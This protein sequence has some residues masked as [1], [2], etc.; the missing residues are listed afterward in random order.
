MRLILIF[1]AFFFSLTQIAL[2]EGP[3]PEKRVILHRDTDFPGGDIQSIFDTTLEACES[4]CLTREDCR[5]FT[6]NSR[7]QACFLKD[8]FGTSESYSGAFSGEIVAAPPAVVAGAEARAERLDFLYESDIAQAQARAR[9]LPREFLSGGWSAEQLLGWAQEAEA[10]AN[11]VSAMRYTA[12]AT[13]ISDAGQDWADYA[14]LANS[15]AFS[16]TNQSERTKLYQTAL[17]AAISGYLRAASPAQEANALTEMATALENLG[18]GRQ[19][20]SALRLAQA[21]SPRAETAEA[22]DRAVGLYGFRV[23]DSSVESDAASPRI[24]AQF[25][26]SLVETGVDYAPFVQSDVSGL[27]VSARG[28]QLCVEGVS[29]GNRYALTLRAGLPA[30]SGEELAKPVQLNL[31][32]RD[33]APSVR[34]PGRAY[35][36][37]ASPDA[38]LPIVAVN[39]SE[40]ELTLSRLPDRNLVR[41]Y[42]EDWFGRALSTWDVSWFNETLAEPIWEGTAQVASELNRDVTTRLP[43]GEALA[44]QPPG[45]YVLHAVVPGETQDSSPPATQWF[46]IS[47]IGLTTMMGADG[48]HVFARSLGSAEPIAGATVQLASRANAVLGE[49]VTDAAGYARFPEGMTSGRAGAEPAMLTLTK[50]DDI[51]FL[52]LTGPAFDLSDRGVEGHAAAPPID[53]FLTT[54][55]G[56]YR[57]GETVHATA[58]ARDDRAEAIEGLPLIAVLSR[59]DGVEYSRHLSKGAGAGGHVFSLPLAGNAPRG[60]WRLDLFADPDA[61]ALSSTTLLVEDFLPERI[62]FD[63]ALSSERPRLTERPR[64]K[65]EARYLFG[66]PAADLAIEGDLR[67]RSTREIAEWPGYRFGPHEDLYG[68]Q[69]GMIPEART[70]ASG[71]AEFAVGFPDAETRGTPLVAEINIRVKE[72]SGRP[73][74]RSLNVPVAP[75]EPLIGIRPG[76]D[77]TVPEGA[78]ASFDLIALAPDLGL[79]AMEVSWELNRVETRYQ[80]YSM[81]GNW[82]WEPTTTRTR[83]ASGE[84]MLGD[85]PVRVS[86]PTDWGRYELVVSE[87][88]GSYVASSVEFFAGWYAPADATTTPDMLEVSLDAPAYAPGDTATLRFVPRAAGKA[89]VTVV[90]NRLIDMVAVDAVAGENTVR[91]PVTE[92]WGAGAYVMATMIRPLDETEGREPTRALGLTH[93]SVDPGA[94]QLAAAFDVPAE[95][96][97]RGPLEVVL[98]VD[99]VADG[100]SAWATIAAVDV[101]ILNLTSFEAP[102]PSDHYFGQRRLG[103]AVRDLYGRLIDG[104]SGAM[105]AIRSG[106]DAMA[107]MRMQAPPP[108]EELMA[109]FSGPVEVIDGKAVARIDLPEFNGTVKLMAV[110]WSKTG[111]GNAQAEVLV[112]DPVVLTASLPRFLAPG[113]EA[114]MLLELTHAKGPAGEMRLSAASD[115]VAVA[116]G[117]FAR[118]VT[119]GEG[120]T[121][122]L[123][124][125]VTAPGV[126]VHQIDLALETPDGVRLTKTLTLPVERLDPEVARTTRLSLAPGQG[127]TLT[128]DMLAGLDAGT[129]RATIT[130]GPLAR[131]DAAGLLDKLDAYPYG[132]T[133]QQA[134]RALPLLYMGGIA[135]AMGLADREDLPGRVRG[136]IA[137]VLANQSSSGAFGVWRPG[138]GDLWLDAYASDFLARART[139]GYEVPDSGFRAAM[140]NLRNRVNYYPDFEDGGQDLAYAL[141]VLAREGAAS[142]GDLRYYADTRA[143]EFAT[144]LASAQIGAALAAYGDPVRADRMFARAMRQIESASDEGQVWR[145]DYGTNLRD[146]AA[147][148]ALGTEA[149]SEAIDREALLGRI[150]AGAGRLS[151]QEAAWSLLAAN[152]LLEEAPGAGLTLDGAALSGPLVRI[153]GSADLARDRVIVN[154]GLRET[155]LTTT[156]IGVPDVAPPAEGNG[157]AIERRYFTMEGEPA[158]PGEVAQGTRLVTLLTVTPWAYSEGRLMITDPLPA[159]FEIDNPNLLRAGD[160]KALDWLQV[161]SET[162]TTEFR[163]DRF[164]AAVD[165]SSDK[166]I[167]LAYVVRAV[168]TGQFH[169]PAASIEDMYR[170]AYRA[171]GAAGTVRVTE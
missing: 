27:A 118:D 103:M 94:H 100:E 67:L 19:M 65:L 110:V 117:G 156:I 29:H 130:G 150:V 59:P 148:L 41:A 129:A 135:E 63:L 15:V 72:G 139:E 83:V 62:D 170:P 143:D 126:G 46:V 123:S 14:R 77:G 171:V 109:Q 88:G 11:I 167:R 128:R 98:E 25:S 47:D 165:W 5:A 70:D 105:G 24:C 137:A 42:A 113:D 32:V 86:A 125:P 45:I 146:A 92:D 26:E 131:V 55:R 71:R 64:L 28:S 75:A 78:E 124:V 163:Q 149:G 127:F 22:I 138:S 145:A 80:W 112:R 34:F 144:P 116:G 160:I 68:P 142:M 38:G 99:G 81:H 107:Q 90:S 134:S 12:A 43:I 121:A 10:D 106:G 108:T 39:A 136:A 89:L 23:T 95:A 2:A 30:A 69:W 18:R 120:E 17:E 159:G 133:E 87:K 155:L 74:E 8:R 35:V 54:D 166:P 37:P 85:D 162:E 114:R 1:F 61:P 31:Y 115:T 101:G 147:V 132:C 79:R 102:D 57:A 4:A 91:L 154:E 13:V 58:L 161:T 168:T 73:V 48:L 3:V 6:Y 97:P 164:L 66:A 33:R 111:V 50:G 84:A 49:A 40:I 104:R 16:T 53:V 151:T 140:D 51:A 60:T 141:Y 52:S 7:S 157:Y 158:D 153:L 56:A 152:A 119:L 44:D 21:A 96:A 122:R 82:N 36:L 20:I 76:F 9:A 93:A 169:H